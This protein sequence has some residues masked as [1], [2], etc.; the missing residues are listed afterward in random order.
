MKRI[1]LSTAVILAQLTFTGIASAAFV[2]NYFTCQENGNP[3][4]V[5]SYSTTSLLGTPDFH[6]QNEFENI[7]PGDPAKFI[8]NLSSAFTAH[9][10]MISGVVAEKH[11]ADAPVNIYTLVIPAIDMGEA[12]S[13]EF[14]TRLLIGKGDGHFAPPQILQTIDEVKTLTCTAQTVNFMN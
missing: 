1:I 6:I 2:P 8:F 14:E 11:I 9:G 13:L 4:Y 3:D 7:A 12:L 5:V 10:N